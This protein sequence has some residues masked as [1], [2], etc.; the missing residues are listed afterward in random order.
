MGPSPDGSDRGSGGIRPGVPDPEP[1]ERLIA[2][3]YSYQGAVISIAEGEDLTA[4]LK[5]LRVR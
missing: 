3:N 4:N 2:T 1:Q 5:K